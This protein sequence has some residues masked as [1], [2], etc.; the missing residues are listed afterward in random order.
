M[1][2]AA[3]AWLPSWPPRVFLFHRGRERRRTATTTTNNP[4]DDK[5][6]SGSGSSG[7]NYDVDPDPNKPPD[8]L[9]SE[10]S[11]HRLRSPDAKTPFTSKLSAKFRQRRIRWALSG[12]L[13]FGTITI[14]LLSTLLT[15]HSVGGLDTLFKVWV[16]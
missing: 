11:Y 6:S 7:S 16:N 1:K 15:R 3:Q 5:I 2:D 10:P 13:V 4:N 12:A 8:M 9:T 14:I